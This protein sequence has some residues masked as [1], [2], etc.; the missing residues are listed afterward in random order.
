MTISAGSRLGPYEILAPIGAGGMGEVYR[1]KDPRLGRE[2]AIKVLPAS[3]S[4]DPDRL[5][6]FEQEARAA[7]M[8]NH[9]NV[10]AVYDIGKDES[11]GAPY[12]VQELLEGETL[13]Q[14]LAGGQLSAKNAIDYGTQIA[15]GLAAAHEK[16]VVHRD[17]K[18]ENLFVG[19]D[20]H[21]KILD[22]GLARI[23]PRV[24]FGEETGA[25]TVSGH[26]EPGTVMGTVGYMSPEQVRGKPADARSDVFS[27]GAV[28]YE[29]LTGRRAFHKETGIETLTAILK[30]EPPELA[31]EA[32][33]LSPALDRVV[34]HCLEKN[35]EQR[36][37]SAHDIAFALT[38]ASSS[39]A[40]GRSPAADVGVR[41]RAPRSRVFRWS[42]WA[43]A[44]VALAAAVLLFRPHAGT[45][46][47]L[48]VLPF[49]NVGHDPNA[50]YLSDGITESLINSVSRIPGVKV[51]SRGSAFYYKGK[52]VGAKAI[53]KQLGVRAVLTGRIVQRGDALSIRA[54][55]VD[56]RDDT[57]LWGEEYNRKLADILALQ[58]EI[59]R[60]ISGKL[61]QRLT[62]EQKQRLSRR[63]TEDP[64]AY[65]SYLKGRYHWNK[66]TGEDLQKG[67]TYFQ[68]AIDKDPTYALA[69]A[70]LADCYALLFLYGGLP[71]AETFPKARAAALK[72]LEIDE[73]L[74]QAHATLA[75]TDEVFS[76]DYSAAEKEYRRAI[77]LDPKY[78]TVHHWYSLFL[79]RLGRHEQAIAEAARAYELDP[80]SPIIS[81]NRAVAF[82][83]SQQS[84]RAIEAS[85]QTLELDSGFSSAHLWLGLALEQKKMYPEAT[86]SLEEAV[87]LSRRSIVTIADLGHVNAVSGKREEAMRLI[88]E[89]KGWMARG[90]D[91]LANIAMVYAGLGQKDEA[92]EWLDKAC[93][94]RSAWVV[95]LAVKVD[96]RWDALRS[97]PRFQDLLRRTGFPPAT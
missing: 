46:D 68:Q 9:P 56:A 21:V 43:A 36:F 85:R 5:R 80:L 39:A 70:G 28:L 17:L 61:R 66:R 18:P 67:I 82:V 91:P 63:A 33:S 60:D 52:E 57:H 4:A 34:R 79:S 95:Y 42:L 72:A 58:E 90:Y 94:A 27:F 93:R 74:A 10:T 14:T 87:R 2:V 29:M 11:T 8:L 97:D 48:A 30:E 73:T 12:V 89:L 51:V 64:E 16:G 71:S 41:A 54:E 86:A 19:K 13:R 78:P 6:R 25:P 81:N 37:Q 75:Y 92:I 59:A 76:W 38:E 44:V 62:G 83:R 55:L 65:G 26:T 69:Y 47:S 35:P 49:V 96:P 45:I 88:E 7:G 50:E 23:E 24:S 15:L 40:P 1:A 32:G 84:D 20:G 53:G 3:F 31:G 22:F 77:E